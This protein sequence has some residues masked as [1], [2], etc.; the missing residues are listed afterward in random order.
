LLADGGR[1][2]LRDGAQFP[3][4]DPGGEPV[5]RQPA[6]TLTHGAH[7]DKSEAW[8]QAPGGAQRSGRGGPGRPRRLSG[9]MPAVVRP[10]LTG[11][12]LVDRPL[13]VVLPCPGRVQLAGEHTVILVE[14]P[15]ISVN[16]EVAGC[17]DR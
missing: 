16:A 8:Q 1:P 7:V 2:A 14:H 5:R 12:G 6:E 3:P 9:R 13:E 4:G 11:R 15:D 10:G 17:P